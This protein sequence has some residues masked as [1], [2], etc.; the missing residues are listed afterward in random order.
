MIRDRQCAAVILLRYCF[1]SFSFSTAECNESSSL[2]WK[3][4]KTRKIH[5]IVRF[6]NIITLIPCTSGQILRVY[7]YLNRK[8]IRIWAKT[9]WL[10]DVWNQSSICGSKWSSTSEPSIEAPTKS[11]AIYISPFICTLW[12]VLHTPLTAFRTAVL[13]FMKYEVPLKT[14]FCVYLCRFRFKEVLL[15]LSVVR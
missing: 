7:K 5:S 11:L 2:I 1:S 12:Y 3:L 15:L 8:R 4:I 14:F 9:M 6:Y 13:Y 10:N